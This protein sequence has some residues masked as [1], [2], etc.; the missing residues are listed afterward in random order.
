MNKIVAFCMLKFD[1]T[2]LNHQIKTCKTFILLALLFPLTCWSQGKITGKVINQADGKSIAHVSVFLNNSTIGTQTD[3]NGAFVLNDVKA[4]KY[5]LV[6]SIIGFNAIQ[7]DVTINST[8]ISMPDIRLSAKTI[9]LQEV[10]IKSGDAKSREKNLKLFLDEF[11]G[12][13]SLSKDCKLLNPELLD[14]NYNESTNVLTASSVDF[15]VIEN[16]RMGYRIKYL[17]DSFYMQK[18]YYQTLSVR[19]SGP[20][21]FT[22]MQGNLSQQETWQRQRKEVYQNSPLHFYRSV[23]ANR[24]EEEGFRVYQLASV[25][26]LSK[27][28][29]GKV[30]EVLQDY[31]L[32]QAD[33]LKATDQPK[34]YALNCANVGLFIT[35]SKNGRFIKN[36]GLNHL[37]DAD[38]TVTTLLRF[39]K[40][41]ALIDI[42]GALLEANSLTYTGTW[43]RYRMGEL[44]PVDYQAALNETAL[45][46][47]AFADTVLTKLKTFAA[48]HIT[49]KAY[50][51]FDKP[52][53]ATGDTAYFKAY[54][55]ADEDHRLSTLSGVLHVDLINPANHIDRS[56]KLQLQN[57]VAWGDFV[58]ADSLPKGNYRLRAYTN[59]MRNNGDDTFF[60]LT[61]PVGTTADAKIPESSTKQASG[62]ASKPDV[63]FFAEGGQLVNGIAN[64]VAFRAVSPQGLGVFL[65]G[66]IVDNSNTEVTNFSASHLGMGY[67]YINPQQGKTYQ[68]RLSYAD[69]TATTLNLP[70]AINAGLVLSVNNDSIPKASVKIEANDIYFNQNRNKD[71]T[72]L[73]YS[74]GVATTAVFKLDKPLIELDI[75][76]RRLHTGVATITL[77]SP[78]A[79]P[80]CERLIFVQN[81]DKL[82]IAVNNDKPVYTTRG[83]VN[84]GLDIKNRA[85]ETVA[86][87]FSVSV[88]DANKVTVDENEENCIM[89][90]L[91]L[92]SDLKG[93]IEQPNYYFNNITPE[94]TANLD[95]VMLTHGYRKFEWKQVLS[96]ATNIP[97]FQPE[98][99]LEISGVAKSVWNKPIVNGTVSLLAKQGGSILSETT[100]E[101]GRFSFKNL[102]FN[103]ST[104]FIL[105]AVN[106]KAGNNTEITYNK[107]SVPPVAPVYLNNTKEDIS[108]LMAVYLDNSKKQQEN[109]IKYMGRK[110]I[111][112]K[113]V[114]IRSVKRD[115]N[116]LSSALGGPGHADKVIHRDELVKMG[117]FIKDALLQRFHRHSRDPIILDGVP[118]KVDDINIF[119]IET[120]ELF[121]GAGAAIYGMQGG[122]GVI[123]ITSRRGS[124]IDPKDVLSH[125]ILPVTVVGFHKAREFY[126][127]KY[128]SINVNVI[129]DLRSTI[130]WNPEVITG[131][132]GKASFKF[133]NAD[134]PGTYRMVI[135][136]IDDNGNIGRQVYS[137]SV[138]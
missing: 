18:N 77:F 76:K 106:S 81:Y 48:Q 100:D 93:F 42:N 35:Y 116:Y 57:G 74:G 113:E 91:L 43:A 29:K 16:Q 69:G 26:S 128:D 58:L 3:E 94:T 82:S 92:K 8:S 66:T 107:E 123:V 114:K 99:A 61:I 20:V 41:N 102:A 7:Q 38:N 6:A 32:H 80:L 104:Q 127:P 83:A 40:P 23:I 17:M 96:S 85:D 75:I 89:A 56:I 4:G 118:T 27:S 117:P 47:P 71:Y 37:D 30:T 78:D 138:R 21:F 13:S 115:D 119:D 79:E 55:T 122:E 50:L 133:Y 46:S 2:A 15:L 31:P 28:K 45:Q 120:V 36:G 44:L 62:S 33:I 9:S 132:D 103:D 1:A 65:K 105:Q 111:A 101:K 39:N 59:W 63:Q 121:Y 22:E 25:A 51:H 10:N 125:G 88:T 68:A 110:P 124:G 126:M 72:L 86:G 134:S 60:E 130:Y 67:F 90:Q 53:Y 129:P 24:M 131:K 84:I 108:Q 137:Y 11:L 98:K 109:A 73:I 19:Y 95:L 54:V 64:K 52:Y 12:T 70:I 136:G 135:E 87:H 14:L 5:Q 49:E 34:I 97:S 112:L